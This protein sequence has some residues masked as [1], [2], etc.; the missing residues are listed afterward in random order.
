MLHAC[1]WHTLTHHKHRSSYRKQGERMWSWAWQSREIMWKYSWN[2]FWKLC[3][4]EV[5]SLWS[6]LPLFIC[7]KYLACI[8]IFNFSILLHFVHR[9]RVLALVRLSATSS[10]GFSGS[11]C[12]HRKWPLSGVCCSIIMLFCFSFWCKVLKRYYVLGYYHALVM[13]MSGVL[14]CLLLPLSSCAVCSCS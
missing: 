11:I 1:Q 8:C 2:I 14:F 6:L 5:R 10:T 4:I 13:Y 3:T 12:C 7:R 9:L